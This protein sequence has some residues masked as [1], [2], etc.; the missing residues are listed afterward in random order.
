MRGVPVLFA[1]AILVLGLASYFAVMPLGKLT[2][3]GGA[4]RW[5]VNNV[6]FD[7]AFR[8]AMRGLAQI[9]SGHG[10]PGQ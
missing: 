6:N 8:S 5:T 7:E 3:A 9:L 4:H 10:E 2:Q 1:A